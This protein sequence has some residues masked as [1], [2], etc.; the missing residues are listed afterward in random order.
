M[1][2]TAF[3]AQDKLICVKRELGLRQ[4]AY[5]R[6]VANGTMRQAASDKEIALMKA[7]IEDYEKLAE[8]ERAAGRLI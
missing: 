4:R 5:P 3:T 1:S 7:I 8:A 2:E 6:W